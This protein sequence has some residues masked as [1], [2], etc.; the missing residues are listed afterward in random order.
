M[1]NII[2]I[3]VVLAGQN[4]LAGYIIEEDFMSG[5]T[6]VSRPVHFKS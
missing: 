1:N 6:L 3:C 2:E 5:Q 4:S